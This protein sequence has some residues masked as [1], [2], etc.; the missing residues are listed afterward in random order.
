M[1]RCFCGL[2][3]HQFPPHNPMLPA[4]C[5]APGSD[6]WHL[7]KD[8][9]PQTH[10]APGRL[11]LLPGQSGTCREGSC[12]A[13]GHPPGGRKR[14]HFCLQ[15]GEWHKFTVA[16][17]SSRIAATFCRNSAT[18]YG[19]LPHFASFHMRL[20]GTHVGK[21]GQKAEFGQN[22]DSLLSVKADQ[23]RGVFSFFPRA[24]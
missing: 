13:G 18:V 14:L 12:G 11:H 2:P 16:K 7:R 5:A 8:H 15:C 17:I 10:H 9:P 3:R 4:T 6:S 19:I 20:L 1:K 23:G 24:T 22:F 21:K